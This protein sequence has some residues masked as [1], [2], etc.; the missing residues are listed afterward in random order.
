MAAAGSRYSRNPL[1]RRR[2]EVFDDLQYRVER[3][4]FAPSLAEPSPASRVWS[5][6]NTQTLKQGEILLTVGR[7]IL[8]RNKQEKLIEGAFNLH[9]EFDGLCGT[10]FAVDSIVAVESAAIPA[11]ASKLELSSRFFTAESCGQSRSSRHKSCD[12]Y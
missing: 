3:D 5:G 7:P 2:Q 1:I 6:A 4:Y 10:G 11:R 9:N 12:F 8:A